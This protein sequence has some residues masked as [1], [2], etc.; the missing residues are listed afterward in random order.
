MDARG[1]HYR[2]GDAPG[3]MARAQNDEPA[4]KPARQLTSPRDKLGAAWQAAIS[5]ALPASEF[6]LAPAG[7]R[8]QPEV[9]PGAARTGAAEGARPR[10]DGRRRADARSFAS[11]KSLAAGRS[12]GPDTRYAFISRLRPEATNTRRKLDESRAGSWRRDMFGRGPAG[13]KEQRLSGF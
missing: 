12:P 10:A 13:R 3:Y 6:P 1:R 9:A 4:R 8:R 5:I 7:D 2:V 11:L